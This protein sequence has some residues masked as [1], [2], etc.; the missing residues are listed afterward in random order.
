MFSWARGE[1]ASRWAVITRIFE[2]CVFEHE[3]VTVRARLEPAG[4]EIGAQNIY[5]YLEADD[6]RSL[7]AVQIVEEKVRS[8]VYYHHVPWE[9]SFFSELELCI[10]CFYSEQKAYFHF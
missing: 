3:G 9:L 1:L 10:L 8:N 5:V 6:N 7:D 2:N 4:A